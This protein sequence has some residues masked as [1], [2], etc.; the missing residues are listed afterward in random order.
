MPTDW[1]VSNGGP[2]LLLEEGLLRE[3]HGTD[4]G[5]A[6]WSGKR[7]SDYERACAKGELGVVPVGL[8][9]GLVVGG[10]VLETAWVADASANGGVFVRWVFANSD[11]DVERALARVPAD[12]FGRVDFVFTMG[13]EG[14]RLFDSAMPGED[15]V[16]RS[17]RVRL[18]P[19]RYAVQTA[20]FE[21]DEDTHLVLHRLRAR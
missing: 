14:A 19:A 2:L 18:R 1:I 17:I 12:S 6:E 7:M 16:T 10:E 15:I 13:S 5:G 21:P 4:V 8:G 11:H 3:W 20:R 9:Q